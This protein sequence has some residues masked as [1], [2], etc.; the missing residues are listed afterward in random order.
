M[1]RK[2]LDAKFIPTARGFT[3]TITTATLDRDG[4]VVIPQGMDSTEFESNPV[5]FWNHDYNQPVGKC[6]SLKREP[7]GIIGDFV[8][9][10]RPDGYE[11]D[12]FP[13]FVASLVG[14]GI[15]RGVS[16]GYMSAEGGT[17]RATPEDRKRYGDTVQTVFSKWKLL[18]V[19]VAPLQ[20]N[21]DALV[22]AINKGAVSAT[23]AKRWL[24][25][26]AATTRH[27]IEIALPAAV[28]ASRAKS[29]PIDYLG[30]TRREL[31]RARGL[32]R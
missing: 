16:I 29:A 28:P 31:A 5:L 21:P 7:A 22:T 8:F 11:G 15:V 14:Q 20:A 23:G 17:R 24:G 18:E 25:F 3:A 4:E 1:N 30:I 27:R 13:E 10:K 9:A 12:Y 26:T 32:L 19:S 6:V 2:T